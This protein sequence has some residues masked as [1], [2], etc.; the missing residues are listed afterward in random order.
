[1]KRAKIQV[2]AQVGRYRRILLTDLDWL[3]P[4]PY[5]KCDVCT[6]S[7]DFTWELLRN[8]ESQALPKYIDSEFAF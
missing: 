7:I 8:A 1:M 6:S 5:S 3:Q 4:Q 2:R